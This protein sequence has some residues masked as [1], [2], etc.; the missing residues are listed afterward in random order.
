MS[1]VRGCDDSL[2]AS[3]SSGDRRVGATAV[4]QPARRD[5]AKSKLLTALRRLDNPRAVDLL[6]E[7]LDD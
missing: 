6:H 2:P 5:R 4:G 7:M 3:R 1:L